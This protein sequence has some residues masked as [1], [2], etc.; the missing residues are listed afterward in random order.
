MTFLVRP[1]DI[2]KDNGRAHYVI[3]VQQV[4]LRVTDCYQGGY[5]DE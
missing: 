1:N 3:L 4:S 2:P 5:R